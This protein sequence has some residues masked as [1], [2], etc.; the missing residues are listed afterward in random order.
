VATTI[1]GPDAGTPYE[2][3]RTTRS[4]TFDGTRRWWWR[5]AHLGVFGLVAEV[6]FVHLGTADAAPDEYTYYACGQ[7]YIRGNF[8]CNPE[9]PP[10]AKEILGLGS[11]VFGDS[12]SAARAVTAIFAIA[13]AYA[14]YLFCRDVAGRVW[15]LVAAAMWGLLPQ[16]GI[17][18]HTTL[19]AV[20]IDRFALLDPFV[21]TFVAC[22]LVAGA[23]L[24][25]RGG[26]RLA[27][28]LGG[29]VAA[30]ACAKA[31]GAL[32]AP[33]AC[34]APLAVRWRR[35]FP[36]ARDAIAVVVGGIAVGAAVYAPRGPAGAVRAIRYMFDFQTAHA[37][38][39]V[40]VNGH[41][42]VSAPWWSDL[43]FASSALGAVLAVTLAVLAIVGVACTPRSG[44]YAF[45]V[46]AS[47]I[48]GVGF[49]LHLSA[50]HYFIDWEPA[51][52]DV[53]ALGVAGIVA[54]ARRARWRVRRP[55]L[56]ATAAAIAMV[57]A[58]GAVR[59]VV[60]A[61]SVRPGPYATAARAMQCDQACLVAY[62]GF[63]GAFAGYVPTDEYLSAVPPSTRANR[64]VARVRG[65]GRETFAPPDV[66][67]LDPAAYVL[68]GSW[69][70]SIRYFEAHWESLGYRRVP[71]ASRIAVYRLVRS[72][73]FG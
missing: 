9:H 52:I 68:H 55:L 72:K 36:V 69:Q 24:A 19:E 44:G 35:G 16:A 28:V 27:L 60:A 5:V 73:A 49:G 23:R 64:V 34:V 39:E 61:N 37:A 31:P 6:A 18:N 21:A 65:H 40:V 50:P 51:L 30:A 47:I 54:H 57:L 58:T 48:I 26:V 11:L 20:R 1:V 70:K 67:A 63:F 45:A 22:A 10:L 42:Y 2:A 41:F 71:T 3:E 32:I 17:E 7:A 43:A 15:G 38:R 13:T 46:G 14:C 53:A 12:I 4:R 56:A 8:G 33:V 29:A 59:T 66:V 25:R 62:V